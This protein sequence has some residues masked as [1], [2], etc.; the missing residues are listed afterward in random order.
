M[1]VC[2]CVCKCVCVYIYMCTCICI[3]Y[4]CVCVCEWVSV[5]VS[6]YGGACVCVCVYECVVCAVQRKLLGWSEAQLR[7]SSRL[8]FIPETP[9]KQRRAMFPNRLLNRP[10]F[11]QRLETGCW[12]LVAIWMACAIIENLTLQG[13]CCH[14]TFVF[15]SFVPPQYNPETFGL[16][17][18]SNPVSSSRAHVSWRLCSGV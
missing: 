14:N 4:V 3:G 10:A 17:H 18:S 2:V 15:C 1:C 13:F 9:W 16:N 8:P 11:W 5:C 6:V 7:D 12:H